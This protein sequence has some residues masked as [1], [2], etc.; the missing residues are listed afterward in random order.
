MN[1][2]PVA[3]IGTVTHFV[4][5]IADEAA[6]DAVE[7]H[8]RRMHIPP[9]RRG[10]V[11]AIPFPGLTLDD[12]Q[13]CRAWEMM[14][15]GASLDEAALALGVPDLVLERCLHEYQPAWQQFLQERASGV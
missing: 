10:R 5:E 1:E 11:T 13:V 12:S 14:K 15:L 6:A 7:D 8:E 2:P 3:A 4:A 9:P